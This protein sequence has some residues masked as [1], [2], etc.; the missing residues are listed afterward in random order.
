MNCRILFF[1]VIA[2]V[3]AASSWIGWWLIRMKNYR[4]GQTRDILPYGGNQP[5]HSSSLIYWFISFSYL[6]FP[7]LRIPPISPIANIN[8]EHQILFRDRLT[9]R[10][11]GRQKEK[12]TG[13]H[14]DGQT[15]VENHIWRE[16]RA[17]NVEH[18]WYHGSKTLISSH[19]DIFQLSWKVYNTVQS[20]ENLGIEF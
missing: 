4:M 3:G 10:E 15:D 1:S 6:S 17:W 18:P 12:Q 20:N 14:I 9:N 5:K 11:T 13:G 2:T 8:S 19:F 16:G 7:S